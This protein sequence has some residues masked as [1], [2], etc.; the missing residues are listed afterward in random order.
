MNNQYHIIGLMSGT[1]LDGVDLVKCLFQK[2]KKWTYSVENSKTIPYSNFWKE[3]LSTLHLKNK[4]EIEKCNLEF[5]EY[6]ATITLQFIE[7]NNLKCKYISSH[8]HTI[9]HDPENNFTLQIGDGK[10]I[11][12][13]T[14]ITTINNFRELDMSLGGQGSPLVPIGDLLLFT[15][16]KYCLNLGG[17]AN[18]SIK[19]N[20]KIIAFDICPVNIVLNK[21]SNQF[22]KEFDFSGEISQSGSLKSD[23]LEELNNLDYYKSSSPKSL[24]REWVEEIIFPILSKY[25]CSKEDKMNTFCEHISIQIGTFLNNESVLITG[26]GTFNNYL[27]DRIKFYSNSELIIPNSEIVNFKE[28]IIFAFLG[29]LKLRNQ[30]NCLSSVTGAKRDCSGGDIFEK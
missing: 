4:N 10:T 2:D 13:C 23:L 22:G 20:D 14:N 17:F 9:F 24:G 6:L 3:K 5:G 26:G 11:A 15:A 7:E 16:Y 12:N 21:L 18:I 19:E 1:S 30:T 27:I 29:I 8:G 25:N 28:A